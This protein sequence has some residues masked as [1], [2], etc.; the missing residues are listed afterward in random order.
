MRKGIYALGGEME[1][2]VFAVQVSLRISVKAY[3]T[4]RTY[5]CRFAKVLRDT[6]CDDQTYHSVKDLDIVFLSPHLNFICSIF[7]IT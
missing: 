3:R 2:Y 7:N 6:T 5:R 1:N 4:L